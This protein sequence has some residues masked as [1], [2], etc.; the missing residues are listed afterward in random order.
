MIIISGDLWFYNKTRQYMQFSIFP[1]YFYPKH[2]MNAF[3]WFFSNHE[4]GIIWTVVTNKDCISILYMKDGILKTLLFYKNTDMQFSIFIPKNFETSDKCILL[5]FLVINLALH[6]Y[7]R[8]IPRIVNIVIEQ[9]FKIITV[10]DCFIDRNNCRQSTDFWFLF[11]Y[12]IL[13]ACTYTRKLFENNRIP[14]FAAPSF[15]KIR[16]LKSPNLS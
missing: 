16:F 5:I 3:Y 2:F 15:V 6:K 7:W 12:Y 11:Y 8:R 13:K 1:I 10:F 14:N 9:I 4:C